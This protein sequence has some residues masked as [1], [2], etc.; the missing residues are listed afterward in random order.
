MSKTDDSFKKNYQQIRNK[1]IPPKKECPKEDILWNYAQGKLQRKEREHFDGHLLACPACLES[2][3]VIRMIEQAKKSPQK[4]SLDL[5]TKAKE[6]LEKQMPL[7]GVLSEERRVL[8]KI[9][10]LWDQLLNKIAQLSPDLD[11]LSG[12]DLQFQ[13]VRKMKQDLKKDLGGFPY[14]KT[15]RINEETMNI[16]IDRSGKEGYLTLKVS[17][18]SPEEMLDKVSSI[19]AV[20]YKSNKI[21][22]SVYGDEKGEA[23][24]NRLKEGEYSLELLTGGKSLGVFELTIAK[25]KVDQ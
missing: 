14:S 7:P 3:K 12:A 17:F 4:I 8:G 2:L 22:S 1:L 20:L 18:Y 15:L 16:E 25:A 9:S 24:F 13:P 6:I 19:R 21:Y 5:H 11:I 10:L 23:V